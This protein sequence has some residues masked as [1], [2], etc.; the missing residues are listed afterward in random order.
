MRRDAHQPTTAATSRP[1]SSETPTN[2]ISV[3]QVSR[4]TVFGFATT[5][6]PNVVPSSV[7][8]EPTAMYG[9]SSSGGVNSNVTDSPARIVRA[10]TSPA[11][12]RRRPVVSPGNRGRPA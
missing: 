4:S 12:R 3:S 5:S 2:F 1:P 10:S 7:T 9:R 11:G 8:G 6:V